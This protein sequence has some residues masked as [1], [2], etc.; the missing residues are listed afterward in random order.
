MESRLRVYVGRER[1]NHEL[2]SYARGAAPVACLVTGPSGAGKSAALARFVTD[3]RRQHPETLVVPHFVG[4]SPRSTSLRE[5]L[6]R[7][8]LS[9]K[10]HFA[11]EEELPEEPAQLTHLFRVFLARV[12][13]T[14]P[15][16]FV[17]DALN[18]LDSADRA[19]ELEWLPVQLPAQVKVVASC[20]SGGDEAAAA[21]PILDA[22]RRRPHHALA[23]EPLTD[24]ERREII[25]EVPSLS[26][27][28]LDDQQLGLLLDNPATRNPLYLLV[29]LE[30]LRGFGSHER[31]TERIRRLPRQ[32]DTV[33]ALFQQ[34]LE[35]LEQEFGPALVARVLGLLA[36][37]RR[38]LSEREL[39]GLT[40]DLAGAD[41]LFPVLRQLRPYLL[42]RGG[43]L[44]FYHRNLFKAVRE[45]YFATPEKQEA[46]HARLADYFH[47]QPFRAA[48][49]PP[50]GA[51]GAR[52]QPNV[53]KV[54]ELPWQRLQAR[55][56]QECE[57]LLT[58][59]DF[60]E[61]KAE[62]GLIFDLAR[63]FRDVLD[64]LPAETP[65][66]L[67][68]LLEEALRRD[69]HF[70]VRHPTALFQC[71]WNS[72]WWYDCPEAA[73]HY[74]PPKEGWPA[75][76]PPWQQPGPHLSDLLES[77]RAAKETSQPDFVWLRSLRPPE[78]PLGTAQQAVFSGHKG[79]VLAVACSADGR[80]LVSGSADGDI[81]VW[82]AEGGQQL[83]C[84]H[85]H[86]DQV[87]CVACTPDGQRLAS[88]SRD[89]TVRLWD[90]DG[91]PA[92]LC[93]RGHAGEVLGVALSRDGQRLASAGHDQTVRIWDAD[94]GR[95]LA[96]L[97]GHT[98]KV[99]GVAFAPDGRRLASGSYDRTVRLWDLDSGK[100]LTCLQGHEGVV[101][102]VAFDGSGER[103]VSGCS[104]GTVGWWD[105]SSGR[106]LA[107]LKEH[108]DRVTA[109]ACSGETSGGRAGRIISASYDATVHV[110]SMEDLRL[111]LSLHG[112]EHGVYGV[113]CSADGRFVVS[114][115][116][117][118]TVRLWETSE[119]PP[120]PRLHGHKH[121]ALGSGRQLAVTT[122]RIASGGRDKTVRVWDVATGRQHA[123]LR[124]HTLGVMCVACSADGRLILSGGGDRTMRLW[125]ADTGQERACY[126]D[127]EQEVAYVLCSAD[128]K[129]VLSASYDGTLCIR[130]VD[131]DEEP[132]RLV[133]HRD[134]VN[135][136]A[137]SPDERRLAS[138]SND[139]TVLIWDV[140]TGR[141][142]L[143]L[144]GHKGSVRWVAWSGDG[145][146]LASSSNDP[147][148]LVWDAATG[149]M[150]AYLLGHTDR[151]VR[152]ALSADGSRLASASRD[153]TMRVW[154]VD[155]GACLAV[156]EGR[157]DVAA[158]ADGARWQALS[159]RLEVVVEDTVS[160]A[161][162][163]FP[164][165]LARV[166][167]LPDGRTWTGDTGSHLYLLRLSGPGAELPLETSRFPQ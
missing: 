67:L 28:T 83:A 132:L 149:Q 52:G 9:L 136:A 32:G 155:S 15:V 121:G 59:L 154:D 43:L 1:S 130:T 39:L 44:D 163:G 19:R 71:L 116:P 4:A 85:G 133:G 89:A 162:A 6:K 95:E 100:E 46:A 20:L 109:V 50:R 77:W 29:A 115:S 137:W 156:H 161:S 38:G 69:I 57:R 33:T 88:G 151:V 2:L 143:C 70:L 135:Q 146:R 54:D 78:V 48:P 21:E 99:T 18:Q 90:A 35:R 10:E 24:E 110:W 167:A 113:A 80:R 60:L 103:V 16:L 66:R 76:G 13:P 26:A 31:L 49:S 84:L 107:S 65:A 55:Q 164:A 45:R 152:V 111:L 22:F 123:C 27:K 73:H 166:T 34:V 112:H 40:A 75:E 42:S 72:C 93:L 128:G 142:L 91:G 8:C 120:R 82:D 17:I 79:E 160:G 125:D 127:H 102:S 87:N 41:D 97:T 53:R 81:L 7:L 147:P 58:E 12:P 61:A 36:V 139:R 105:A 63:D 62:A 23:L 94:T 68:A 118:K 64:A 51:G 117:D 141:Q 153:D 25:R 108:K 92:R 5:L 74:D 124:G 159:R 119:S 98:N 138:A 140:S 165:D 150:L 104:D 148:V 101:T 157:G 86:E 11:F 129:R 3:Y 122:N 47:G 114:G 56:W 145:Q 30:E 126:R 131:G 106:Q 96:C 134:Q 14:A 158:L 144:R 37:A